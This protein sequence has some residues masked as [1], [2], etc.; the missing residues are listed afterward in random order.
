[1]QEPGTLAEAMARKNIAKLKDLAIRV[2]C[3]P[4][5][6]SSWLSGTHLPSAYFLGRLS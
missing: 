1:M 3:S 4:R 6:L 2:G 5:S